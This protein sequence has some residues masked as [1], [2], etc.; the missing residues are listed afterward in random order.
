MINTLIEFSK[1]VASSTNEP[2]YSR[3]YTDKVIFSIKFPNSSSQYG[4]IIAVYV[5]LSTLI[6]ALGEYS[7]SV[8]ATVKFTVD[9]VV[10]P[11]FI[12][13]TQLIVYSTLFSRSTS[14]AESVTFNS[15]VI[16]KYLE[17]TES[18]LL[19]TFVLPTLSTV[20]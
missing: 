19:I 2:S 9:S 20:S 17:Y 3:L 7:L 16:S 8:Q 10:K 4:L 1:P 6:S 14:L 5:S 12:D 11:E 15:E 13:T 18:P